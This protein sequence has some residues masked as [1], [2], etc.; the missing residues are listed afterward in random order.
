M[1]TMINMQELQIQ[2]KDEEFSTQLLKKG[3]EVT[4][5]E[6]TKMIN[7]FFDSKTPGLPYFNPISLN[8][9]STSDKTDYNKMFKTMKEDLNNAYSIYNNQTDYSVVING[10]YDMRMESANKA[11]DALILETEILEEYTTKKMAYTPCIINFNDLSNVNTKNLVTHNIPYTTSEIDYNTSTLRNELQ[12]MP[13]DKLDLSTAA[14]SITASNSSIDLD[15][16]VSVIFSELLNNPLSVTTSSQS[17]SPSPLTISIELESEKSI[18]RID[19]IGYSLYN[20]SITL[21]L[22]EDGTNFFEKKTSDG[23]PNMIWRFNETLVKSIK[24]VITKN[25]YDYKK[26]DNGDGE[27]YFMISNLSMYLDKYKKTSVFT[28]KVIEIEEAISDV[29]LSPIHETPP[30]TD[31]AYFVGYENKNDNV[32]WKSVTPN[33]TTDLGL[34]Y[35]EEMIL[36]YQV[37]DVMTFGARR[38]DSTNASFYFRIHQLPSYTNLNSIELRAGHSQWLLEPL[39]ATDKYPNNAGIPTDNKCHTNDYSKSRVPAIA[40][41]DSTIMEI[42]CEKENNYFLM[43]QYAICEQDIIIE[44]RYMEFDVVNEKFDV[45]TL[46]NGKQIFPKNG[47][48]TFRLK[49]GENLVQIMVLLTNHTVKDANGNLLDK[50][51]TIRHNFNLVSYTQA[52]YAGPP[53]ERINYNGLLKNIDSKSLKYYAIK[54]ENIKKVDDTDASDNFVNMIVTKFDP[55]FILKPVDPQ[56]Y[57]DEV[58]PVNHKDVQAIILDKNTATIGVGKTLQL[59]ATIVP[60]D[61]S[62]KV[63]RWRSSN[64]DTI[65][66]SDTGLVTGFSEGSGYIMCSSNDGTI[67]SRCTIIV[68]KTVSVSRM[69]K[70]T[71]IEYND[72]VYEP[73]YNENNDVIKPVEGQDYPQYVKTDV[74]LNNSAYMRMY[75]KFKHMLPSI[76]ESI[77]NAD[78]DANVRLR[79]MAKLST[80]DVTVSPVI[81][82]IKVVGE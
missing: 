63:L 24:I 32:E 79:V 47:K 67:T 54:Q 26:D 34:L 37:T 80:G 10:D 17:S 14:I 58:T 18:S 59:N 71:T 81:K 13:N 82:A 31:I 43:S 49:T 5:Y 76:R 40:A 73:N 19:L 78:G 48:Y 2:Q 36:N 72:R 33:K 70:S 74:H 62:D 6:V 39:D 53:M 44:N 1:S 61:A 35:K 16:D 12:S 77:T 50:V 46:I 9:Y 30:K 21:Y 8:K 52:L 56:M 23:D 75:I 45:I 42:R 65:S 38:Y 4:S 11:I 69:L 7:A 60:S 27:C 57:D 20:T 66:V 68:L 29:T 22:S 51:K 64:S 15:K 25:D 41:L 3:H 28:S 55:N